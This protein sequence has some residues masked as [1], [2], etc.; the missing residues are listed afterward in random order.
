MRVAFDTNVLVRLVTEDDAA[1]ARAAARH[2]EGKQ[3][4]LAKTVLLESEWVL[5]Y[6]YELPRTT[7]AGVFRKV[8]GLE[9]LEVEAASDVLVALAWYEEG[10]DFADAL[11]LASSRGCD[12]LATF[13]R[14][15]ASAARKLEVQPEVVLLR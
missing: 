11:H 9:G 4:F 6:A 1:Q 7:I 12:H 14:H 5:R 2:L 10:L 3:L 8:L 13:D 15:L